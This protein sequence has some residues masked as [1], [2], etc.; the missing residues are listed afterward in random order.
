MGGERGGR[1][2]MQA[3]YILDGEGGAQTHSECGGDPRPE[4]T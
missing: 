4:E 1:G 3:E 2:D